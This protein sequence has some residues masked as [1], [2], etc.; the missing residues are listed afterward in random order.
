LF[1]KFDFFITIPE[2]T[3]PPNAFGIKIGTIPEQTHPLLD[4]LEI[5][6]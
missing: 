3:H 5:D 1:L 6:L 2:Q 4:I